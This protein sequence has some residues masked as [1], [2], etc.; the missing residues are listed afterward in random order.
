ME[1]TAPGVTKEAQLETP[2]SDATKAEDSKQEHEWLSGL[3]LWIIMTGVVL[4]VFLMLLDTSIIATV[5]QRATVVLPQP[6]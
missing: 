2:T 3:Q 6:R 1:K 4:P 5:S